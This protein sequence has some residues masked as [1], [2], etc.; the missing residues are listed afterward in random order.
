MKTILLVRHAKSDWA[1]PSLSDFERPLNARGKKNA[2][3]MAQRLLDR[4]I[5]IDL[6]IS[7]PANRAAKTAKI[8]AEIFGFKKNDI[9]L[10]EKL[11]LAEPDVFASVIKEINNNIDCA[12]IFSHNPGITYFANRL[13]PTQIDNIPT[14]GI[15]AVA[16][17]CEKWKD[18]EN[19]EKKFLFFD[20]PKASVE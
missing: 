13:T 6:F 9:D 5:N 15:F 16:A 10:R 1:D 17:N 3:E 14:C 8:F 20:Y 2:P 19:S 7:S 18:F 12:A 11:Y 4:K